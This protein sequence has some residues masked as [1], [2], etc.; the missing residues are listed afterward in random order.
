MYTKGKKKIKIYQDNISKNF[1]KNFIKMHL[2]V[3]MI[4]VKTNKMQIS[5]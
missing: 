3:E 2:T 5:I 1:P 4:T